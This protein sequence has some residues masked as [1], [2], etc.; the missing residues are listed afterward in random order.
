MPEMRESEFDWSSEMKLIFDIFN[1]I[2]SLSCCIMVIYFF[3]KFITGDEQ[4]IKT[5]WYGIA[6]IAFLIVMK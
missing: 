3:Y 1:T 6:A 4:E 2:M 5:L